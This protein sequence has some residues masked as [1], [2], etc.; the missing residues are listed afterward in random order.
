MRA[1]TSGKSATSTIG[2]ELT[3]TDRGDQ[4]L[5]L[6]APAIANGSFNPFIGADAPRAGTAN[7]F[8]YDNAAALRNAGYVALAAAPR[9]DQSFDGKLGGR[10]LT[11]LPQGGASFVVGFDLRQAGP[12]E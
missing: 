2:N 3:R 10:V 7:G 11:S 1:I 9:R 5:S 8:T 6:L 4:Q 12:D